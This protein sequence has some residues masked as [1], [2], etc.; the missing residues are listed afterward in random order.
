MN[1]I[2]MVNIVHQ[3]QTDKIDKILLI[4]NQQSDLC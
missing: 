1:L 2:R 3:T 4:K